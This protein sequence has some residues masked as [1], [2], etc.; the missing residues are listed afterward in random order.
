[1]FSGW[2]MF[3]RLR[4]LNKPVELFAVPNIESGAH[5]LQNP[6]QCKVILERAL[7]WWLF[8]LLDK[9]STSPRKREQYAEW[10][11]L[12]TQRDKA[13]N[14]SRSNKL[15]WTSHPMSSE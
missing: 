2:E 8:W 11:R 15:D 13:A 10:A 7:D 6:R 4:K 5:G 14:A 1:M 9:E 3:T 12:R